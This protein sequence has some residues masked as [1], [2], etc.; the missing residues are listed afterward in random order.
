MEVVSNS[1]EVSAVGGWTGNECFITQCN[2]A[3]NIYNDISLHA[4]TSLAV[5]YKACFNCS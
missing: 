5:C 2:V 4:Q 1:Y 3:V